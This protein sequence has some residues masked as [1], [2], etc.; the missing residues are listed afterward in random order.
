MIRAWVLACDPV[1]QYGARKARGNEGWDECGNKKKHDG[2][3]IVTGALETSHMP[4][5]PLSRCEQV[6]WENFALSSSHLAVGHVC[7]LVALCV[8][9]KPINKPAISG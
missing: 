5:S 2:T 8:H 7:I 9:E 3:L 4:A 1:T 6:M